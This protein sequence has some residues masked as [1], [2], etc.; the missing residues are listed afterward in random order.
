MSSTLRNRIALAIFFLLMAF[1]GVCIVIYIMVG[2]GWNYAATEI[3]DSSGNMQEYLVVV[4]DGTSTTS[5]GVSSKKNEN[6]ANQNTN[7]NKNKNQNTTA[8]QN[9][10]NTNSSAREGEGIGAQIQRFFNLDSSTDATESEK[11]A[12]DDSPIIS[13]APRATTLGDAYAS[14]LEKGADVLCL[15]SRD[16]SHYAAGEIFYKGSYTVGVLGLTEIESYKQVQAK[17]DA[18]RSRGANAVVVL[19]ARSSM[20]AATK[21]ANVC[22]EVGGTT[23]ALESSVSGGVVSVK[24]SA[25]GTIDAVILS[26]NHIVSAKML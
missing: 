9:T 12:I 26:P 21:G 23:K 19:A 20:L 16:I 25:I 18:L 11:D 4:F 7:K 2:H 3:D 6:T 17:I 1:G 5:D 13:S 15:Y 14:Y 22:I 24:S 8:N 10:N